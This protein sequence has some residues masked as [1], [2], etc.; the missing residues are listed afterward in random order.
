MFDPKFSFNCGR[1]ERTEIGDQDPA[2]GFVAWL[3]RARP[4]WV[5]SARKRP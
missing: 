3:P 4:E 1:D 2:D 5:I